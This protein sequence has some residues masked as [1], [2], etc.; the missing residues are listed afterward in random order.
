MW[1]IAPGGDV[2]EK[3]SRECAGAI[4]RELTKSVVQS[5]C[6]PG[7]SRSTFARKAGAEDGCECKSKF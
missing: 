3:K 2:R 6:A 7:W 5:F 1:K 4:D